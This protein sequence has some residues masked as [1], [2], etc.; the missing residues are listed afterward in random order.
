MKLTTQPATA[1][2]EPVRKTGWSRIRKRLLESW[3]WYLMALP[4]I[5]YTIIFDYVSMY[6][7]VMA[8]QDYKA[9]KGF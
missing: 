9:S 7:I 6:G 4:A 8:F 1:Q 5:I 3:P 2:L